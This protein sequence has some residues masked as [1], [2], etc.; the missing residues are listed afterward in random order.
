MA[1]SY[2]KDNYE[3]IHWISFLRRHNSAA[4]YRIYREIVNLSCQKIEEF[5]KL[6]EAPRL[7]FDNSSMLINRTAIGIHP[8]VGFVKTYVLSH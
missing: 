5:D 1:I 3:R 4:F 2:L 6:P 8:R 7:N